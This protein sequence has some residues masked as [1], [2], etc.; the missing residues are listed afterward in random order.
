MDRHHRHD[1][2]RDP[3]GKV[4]NEP[5]FHAFALLGKERLFASHLTML[6]VE[7]H[8]YQL[9]MEVSLPEP[10]HSLFVKERETNPRD[11]YFIANTVED[12]EVG[13]PYS[14]PMTVPELSGGLRKS[15][16]GNIFRGIPY[17]PAYSSWPWAGVRPVIANI[18]VNMER[19]VHFRPFA[20][21]LSYPETLTYLLF[22][23]GREAHMVNFQTKKPDF[24]HVLSLGAAPDWLA[25]DLLR[26]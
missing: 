1:Q 24:D 17:K 7:I 22:G 14:D 12:R 2:G 25:Q 11:S 19:I 18:P 4:N 15:F 6:D 26:A 20:Q 5:H 8:M 21:S 9:V 16:I 23:A 10:Y 13:N 3:E